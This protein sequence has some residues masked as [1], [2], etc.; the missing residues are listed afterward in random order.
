M[1]QHLIMAI[2]ETHSSLYDENA[3]LVTRNSQLRAALETL[4]E[5]NRRL[6]QLVAEMKRENDHPRAITSTPG[7]NGERA[8]RVRSMLRAS[9]NP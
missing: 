6:R 9:R 4:I 1:N 3:K 2:S 5:D 8:D 7:T